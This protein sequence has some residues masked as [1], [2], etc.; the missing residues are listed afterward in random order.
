MIEGLHPSLILIVGGALLL[1]VRGSARAWLT[2][3]LPIVSYVHFMGLEVGMSETRM[4][5][6]MELHVL[7]VDKMA[8]L[9]GT[10]FHVAALI[11][12]IYAMH[13]KDPVQHSTGMMY[14]GSAVGA[15]LAANPLGSPVV[16]DGPHFWAAPFEVAGEFGGLGIG[17]AFDPI[18]PVRT[19]VNPE[20]NTVIAVVATDAVLTKAQAKRMAVAAHDGIAR[21]VVPS[22]TPHDGDLVFAAATGHRPL[23]DPVIDP[24]MIGHAAAVCVT[25]ALARAV[26][27]ATPGENDRVPT[28][29]NRFGPA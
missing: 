17:G 13:V 18:G 14:A 21:A 1:A 12:G 4:M 25:R 6:G 2:V 24:L 23:A 8:L 29:Q 22:H 5:A 15:V 7:Y 27:L 16:G 9:F 10:L 11:A 19:K 20:G 3:A 28:W 26:Y